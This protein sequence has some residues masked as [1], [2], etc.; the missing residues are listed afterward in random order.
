[1]IDEDNCSTSGSE[2][3]MEINDDSMG[4]DNNPR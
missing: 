4:A 2:R 3:S 1:M